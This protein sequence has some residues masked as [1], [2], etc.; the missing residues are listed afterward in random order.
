MTGGRLHPDSEAFLAEA[1]ALPLPPASG[2]DVA[3][4]RKRYRILCAHFA[5]TPPDCISG[6]EADSPVPARVYRSASPEPG[7]ALLWFHGGRMICGDLDT[8]DA[9]CRLLAGATRWD[10]IAF[11]Y[12]LAPEHPFP[13]ALEDAVAALQW[14]LARY[15]RVAAGGDSAGAALAL[16]ATLAQPAR[17]SALALVYPMLDATLAAS[18]HERFRHGPGT[19]SEDIRLGYDLWLPGR[20]SR[21]HPFLTSWRS[22]LLASLPPVWLLTAEFDPLRDEGEQFLSRVRSLGVDARH[23]FAAGHIHGF[24]TYPGR[25]AAARE[26][27]REIAAFLTERST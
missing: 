11:D 14:A 20:L 3:A 17:L 8:H 9:A 16:H 22:P 23:H 21:A 1:A 5:G 6:E 18:S 25:F 7:R 24:L 15:E 27:V 19:S 13:A 4:I 12:R 2:P 26:S 10:V